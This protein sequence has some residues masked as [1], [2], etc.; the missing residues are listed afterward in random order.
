MMNR[1]LIKFQD[2]ETSNIK[3]RGEVIHLMKGVEAIKN[4][5]DKLTPIITKH[6]KNFNK[7]NETILP[8]VKLDELKKVK[9][10]H[11]KRKP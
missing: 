11:Q 3:L 10:K 5:Q 2:M 8:A 9:K 6:I 7:F 4:T 1:F